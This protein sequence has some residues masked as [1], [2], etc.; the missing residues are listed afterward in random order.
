MEDNTEYSDEGIV[1]LGGI[2]VSIVRNQMRPRHPRDHYRTPEW[3]VDASLDWM[4]KFDAFNRPLNILDAGMGSGIWGKILRKYTPDSFITGIDI[5]SSQEIVEENP[6]AKDQL[7]FYDLRVFEASFLDQEKL[8]DWRVDKNGNEYS[9]GLK[10]YDIVLGNPPFSK[11]EEFFWNAVARM[12]KK[13]L[14]AIFFLYPNNFFCTQG[15]T[16]RIF[17]GGYAPTREVRFAERLSFTGDGH[18]YP[19]G[20]Y[21]MGY[22]EFYDQKCLEEAQVEWLLTG[23]DSDKRKR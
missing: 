3:A 10:E 5:R 6:E 20:E 4:Q 13:G 2:P 16:K 23:L 15:R 18:S 14:G 9:I 1:Y 21:S 22:W 12:P 17:L 11:Q 19:G 7:G 8:R